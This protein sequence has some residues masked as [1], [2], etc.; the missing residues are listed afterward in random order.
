M[1]V[2]GGILSVELSEACNLT[3]GS[4]SE[5]SDL[6]EVPCLC[7]TVS[8]TGHGMDAA[9]I[10][11]IFD[12]YF[13][14][15]AT[16]EGTGLGLSVAQ[17]IIK[18]HGGKITV[19]S[20]P[21]KGTTFYVFLPRFEE[22]ASPEV[23]TVETVPTG[24]ERILFVDDE[25]VLADLG[26]E[27]LESLGYSVTAK[28]GSLEALQAFSGEP[29]SFDLIITDMTMPEITG[30]ELAKEI[31]AIRTNIPIILCTG[32]S[33]QINPKQAKEAGIREL[34]IKPYTVASLA[35]TIRRVLEQG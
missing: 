13:T 7:L 1:R 34:V 21:G 35:K 30:R 31:M 25:Q 9:V 4:G 18:S 3:P 24:S 20:E 14:T 16:G 28:T 22:M 33:D 5:H 12:P 8:D 27:I 19:S 10:E 17:G 29:Y 15:K 26:K 23:P 6:E 32:F 2:K 11:R